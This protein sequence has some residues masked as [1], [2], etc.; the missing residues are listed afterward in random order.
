MWLLLKK[1]HQKG[2]R[3]GDKGKQTILLHSNNFNQNQNQQ[4]SHLEMISSLWEKLTLL[5]LFKPLGNEL[6]G[7]LVKIY[8]F[9][10]FIY[11]FGCSGS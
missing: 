3:F 7:W 10:N 2:Q 11:L 6:F 8:S 5:S 9:K 4:N 1:N